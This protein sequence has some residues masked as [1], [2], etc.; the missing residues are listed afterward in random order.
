VI[1]AAAALAAGFRY[2]GPG[3][4]E[5]L[6]EAVDALPGGLVRRHFEDFADAVTSIGLDR[7]EELHTA[8]LDL[9]PRFAP[10]V[11]HAIWADNYQRGAFMAELA[12]AQAA[13]GVDPAGE[14]PDHVEPVLRYLA[15]VDHPLDE[16]T[17]ILPK[18]LR[19][20]EES[21]GRA[22]PDNPYRSLLDA[23]IALAADLRPL[24]I[25]G[26]SS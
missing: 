26:G 7:W 1:P 20:M 21:L 24:T 11:G 8:T 17:E 15:V 25:G 13:A 14:L 4:A 19:S 12:A 5:L 10:Y 23:C 3:S 2:P 6:A 22:E 16:L 18:A 9:G